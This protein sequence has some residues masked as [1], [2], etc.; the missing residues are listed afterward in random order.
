MGRRRAITAS[1]ILPLLILLAGLVLLLAGG[2][3]LVGGARDLAR[4]WGMPSL[5]IGLTVVAFGTSVPEL[6]ISLAATWRGHPE[7]MLGNVIGS[8]V[9][10]IGLI[11]GISLLFVP[12]R[13]GLRIVATEM[14]LLHLATAGLFGLTWYGFFPRWAGGLCVAALIAYTFLAY[15][16]AG[17]QGGGETPAAVVEQTSSG[18]EAVARGQLVALLLVLAGLAA[19]AAGAELFLRGAVEIARG[20]GISEL[21]IG[22]TLAAIGTSLPELATCFAAIRQR[23]DALLV[24]NIIGSN[25]FNLLMVMGVTASLLPFALP[26][27]LLQRDLPVMLLFSLVLLAAIAVRG[28]LD[29]VLGVMLLTGYAAYLYWLI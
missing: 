7:I 11:L 15:W 6:F 3:L 18:A 9:A 24:G 17:G 2:E 25:L 28:R 13:L 29:R 12:L 21:V 19:L 5:L 22:L 14:I 20:L 8:N 23:Q 27:V 16:R 26:A 10:N 1:L 4:H